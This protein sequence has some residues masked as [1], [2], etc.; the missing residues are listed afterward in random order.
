MC[1]NRT[2]SGTLH[3]VYM[4]VITLIFCC[5]C[6]FVVRHPGLDAAYGCLCGEFL[7]QHRLRP[8]TVPHS[9]LRLLHRSRHAS[10]RPHQCYVSRSVKLPCIFPGAPLTSNGAPGNIQ[11]NIGRLCVSVQNIPESKVDGANM[12][13]IW[14]RQ[15]PGGPH[16]GRMNFVWYDIHLSARHLFPCVWIIHW[17]A[18][19]PMM[20]SQAV[21]A[22]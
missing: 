20:S 19:V 14:G 1:Q 10:H 21:I 3:H 9:W 18:R 5:P 15:D 2:D 4:I 7:L 17:E 16:D 13:P 12:G 6:R 8:D 11:S 22:F